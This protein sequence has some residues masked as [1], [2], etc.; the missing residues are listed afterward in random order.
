MQYACIRH[1]PAKSMPLKPSEIRAI[2][3]AKQDQFSAFDLDLSNE[4]KLYRQA[5]GVY[6]RKPPTLLQQDLVDVDCPGARPLEPFPARDWIYPARLEWESREESLAWVRD[7]LS[8]V[9][10][11]AVDGSQVFPSKDISMP[12]ALVQIGW[13]LNP[14]LSAGEYEKDVRVDVLSP[15]ELQRY[16]QIRPLDRQVSMHRFEMEVKRLI[17]FMADHAGCSTCLAFFDGSLVASFAEVLDLDCRIFYA[18][19]FVEL[20]RASER[21]Q[22]P[23]VGYVDTSNAR[24]LV[25][26]LAYLGE[27]PEAKSVKD[28]Q[29][30]GGRMNWGDRTPLFRCDRAGTARTEG[31]L[32]QYEEQAEAI[33]FTYLQANNGRPVRLEL[34]KW[35]YEAGLLDSV[36]DYVRAEIIVGSGYPYAIETADQVAVIRANDRQLFYRLLQDWATTEDLNLRFSRKMISKVFRRR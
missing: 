3:S 36:M 35:I 29:L 30:F 32:S 4:L 34:P 13:F 14:H 10:T 20:L 2:L 6:S 9:T 15:Q 1:Y 25:D 7:R 31:I 16:S 18:F 12:V 22:V 27:L 21:Y 17:E 8:G 24:D 11:F 26:M 28:V 33:T 5:L 23:L 19:Q